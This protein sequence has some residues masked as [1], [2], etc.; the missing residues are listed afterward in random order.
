MN[1]LRA[2]FL[3][4]RSCRNVIDY[5]HVLATG[6]R[7]AE[8]VVWR[9]ETGTYAMNR[10][11]FELRGFARSEIDTVRE[12]A[13]LI[14]SAPAPVLGIAPRA[15]EEH[16]LVYGPNLPAELRRKAEIM[17]EHWGEYNE[18]FPPPSRKLA[19]PERV[20]GRETRDASREEDND[21]R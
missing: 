20:T 3:V 2:F 18:L 10:T 5:A 16:A 21:P 6:E 8:E 15:E 1:G 7:E 19:R 4:C 11:G 13:D 14:E 9:D 17:L 12:L